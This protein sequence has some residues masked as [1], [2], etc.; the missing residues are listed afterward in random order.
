VFD[1]YLKQFS[2]YNISRFHPFYIDKIFH[3]KSCKV[4]RY[5]HSVKWKHESMLII[6]C[7]Y[8]HI[9]LWWIDDMLDIQEEPGKWEIEKVGTSYVSG[10]TQCRPSRHL[11]RLAIQQNHKITALCS[12]IKEVAI[13]WRNCFLYSETLHRTMSQL[14]LFYPTWDKFTCLTSLDERSTV[15]YVTCLLACYWMTK[16]QRIQTQDC[17]M[18]STLDAMVTLLAVL[19]LFLTTSSLRSALWSL[20]VVNY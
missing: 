5:R 18:Y 19:C 7:S 4:W 11:C 6:I 2:S 3:S 8:E 16:R 13:L 12:S 20:L 15:Q 9:I 14:Y 10:T 17:N 1:G